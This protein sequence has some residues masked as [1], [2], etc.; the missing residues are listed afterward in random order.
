MNVSTRQLDDKTLP[1]KFAEIAAQENAKPEALLLEVTE[2]ALMSD[3]ETNL[4]VLDELSS[5][6]MKCAVDD[7]GTGNASLAQL[8]RLPANVLK[9]DRM[10]IDDID[11][12]PESRVIVAASIRMGHALGMQIVAEGIERIE[13]MAELQTLGC[14][15]VQGYY[16]HIPMSPAALLDVLAAQPD[17]ART[18][19]EPY[20]YIA[21]MSIAKMPTDEQSLRQLLQECQRANGHNG[22]TGCLL[23]QDKVFMQF[24]EGS[25]QTVQAIYDRI[26][27]DPRHENVRL[28][29]EGR[30]TNRLFGDWSMQ[31]R[32]Y[33]SPT[34]ATDL[35]A[36]PVQPSVHLAD[37]A[38]DPRSCLAFL[39]AHASG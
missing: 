22:I 10:F 27:K 34:K 18:S 12:R 31:L 32:R 21:Y 25:Q 7:F 3:L 38:K 39:R 2:T 37:L 4:K 6:G 19:C 35:F 14:D 30:Q 11:T 29:A 9:V 8:L 28:I 15:H 13:Q 16:C 33:D 17:G 5:L 36:A 24:F 1:Q 23:V 20:Y 26:A